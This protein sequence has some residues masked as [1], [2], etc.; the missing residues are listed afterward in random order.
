MTHTNK[1]EKKWEVTGVMTYAHCFWF[2]DIQATT[3]KKAV[4]IARTR[5]LQMY[6]NADAEFQEILIDKPILNQ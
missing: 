5:A 3:R 6:G 2:D 1:E 4:E